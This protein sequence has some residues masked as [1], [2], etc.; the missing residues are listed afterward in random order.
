[1]ADVNEQAFNSMTAGADKT[2]VDLSLSRIRGHDKTLDPLFV[3][4][5]K[6]LKI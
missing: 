3:Q 5:L 4:W 1:M 6:T 2:K